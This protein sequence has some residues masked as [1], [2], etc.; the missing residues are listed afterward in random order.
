VVR[1]DGTAQSV[2]ISAAQRD[3]AA[4][5]TVSAQKLVLPITSRRQRIYWLQEGER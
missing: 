5:S 1:I 4:S 3:G 2:I